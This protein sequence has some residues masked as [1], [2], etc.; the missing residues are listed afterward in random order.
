MNWKT[1]AHILAILS[2]LPGGRSL[3]HKLQS[4]LGTNRLN[5]DEGVA[6]A[7]ELVELIYEGGRQLRGS[8]VV[9]VGTGW[10]PFV[11]F[12]FHLLGADSI[13]TLDINPWLNRDYA[14]ETF[15][16]LEDQLEAIAARAGVDESFVRERYI[17]ATPSDTSLESLLRGFHVNYVYPGDARATG[18]K[19]GSIDFVVSSNVLEHV[20]PEILS[21]IHIESRRIL[22]ADGLAVHRFNPEDHY[23]GVD[24]SITGANFLQFSEREWKWYGGTGLAYHNRLRC[25]EHRELFERAGFDMRVDRRR[26]DGKGLAAIKNGSLQVHADFAR[27]SPEDLATDYMWTVAMPRD[28]SALDAVGAA[29]LK[30]A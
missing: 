18:L 10:R 2:R 30:L 8:A 13:R 20:Q 12:I 21:V 23:V 17:R 4:A 29:T 11:P 22:G 1:K 14:F 5:V 25:C 28:T 3:Y 27:F 24:R 19:S 9:E 6:R 26:M 7:M 15:H 16:A